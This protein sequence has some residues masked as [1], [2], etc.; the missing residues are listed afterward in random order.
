[1]AKSKKTKEE[2]LVAAL[3]KESVKILDE[4][5]EKGVKDNFLFITTFKRYQ[6]QLEIL[7]EHEKKI[8]EENVLVEKE[9]VKGRKNLYTNPAIAEFNKTTDSANKT[10][11]CLLGLIKKETKKADDN[12]KD[13]LLEA[14]MLE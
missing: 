13:P 11:N 4:A 9:Y 10:V 2:K 12:Q 7:F 8:K 1:M 6:T 14:L 3:K 5:K